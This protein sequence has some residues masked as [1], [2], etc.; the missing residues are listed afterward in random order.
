MDSEPKPKI[1][2]KLSEA[3][4][5]KLNRICPPRPIPL[6]EDEDLYREAVAIAKKHQAFTIINI[7]HELSWPPGYNVA[8]IFID[9]MIKENIVHYNEVLDRYVVTW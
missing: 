9:R 4:L 8:K 2:R 6:S 1:K 5:R 3:D 7:I